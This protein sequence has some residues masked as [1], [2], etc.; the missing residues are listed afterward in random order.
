M[1]D[2]GVL[3]T[4][5]LGISGSA[6][7]WSIVE[8]IDFFINTFDAYKDQRIKLLR[9]IGPCFIFIPNFATPFGE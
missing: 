1:L 9:I 7:A 2:D 5:I 3:K 8:I 4:V 6:L